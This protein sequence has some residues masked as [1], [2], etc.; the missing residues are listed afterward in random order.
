VQDTARETTG[1]RSR[2]LLFSTLLLVS[3]PTAKSL[4][5][6]ICRASGRMNFRLLNSSGISNQD[7]PRN[8]DVLD[9]VLEDTW[10][11]YLRV[12]RS[13]AKACFPFSAKLSS[14]TFRIRRR[15]LRIISYRRRE[16]LR[17]SCRPFDGSVSFDQ[18]PAGKEARRMT[19]LLLTPGKGESI[20]MG[21]RYCP[22]SSIVV[23]QHGQAA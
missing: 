17:F 11:P 13:K 1:G 8:L 10:I 9:R 7:P 3:Y 18:A 19:L 16:I 14:L 21:S 20:R 22:A 12:S 15:G 5:P 2:S 6:N 4:C 23:E